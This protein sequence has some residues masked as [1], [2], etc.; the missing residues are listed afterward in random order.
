M[1]ALLFFKFFEFEEEKR[2]EVRHKVHFEDTLD[3]LHKQYQR[4]D[5][6]VSS[7]Q[8]LATFITVGIL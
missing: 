2:D 5:V 7:M 8:Q 3:T 6:A 4:L 1:I